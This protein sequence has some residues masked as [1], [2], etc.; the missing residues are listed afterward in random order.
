MYKKHN[1]LRLSSLEESSCLG[2]MIWQPSQLLYS[3]LYY[4][5]GNSF[6]LVNLEK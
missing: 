3:A 2:V 1:Y 4:F 6:P 5:L